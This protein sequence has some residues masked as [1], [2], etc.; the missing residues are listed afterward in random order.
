M[1]AARIILRGFQ[2]SR[3]DH[4]THGANTV[5]SYYHF[6]EGPNNLNRSRIHRVN[7]VLSLLYT[8][9]PS[10]FNLLFSAHDQQFLFFLPKVSRIKDQASRLP[11]CLIISGKRKGKGTLEAPSRDLVMVAHWLAYSLRNF[12]C[13]ESAKR[14]PG[15]F[16]S[17]LWKV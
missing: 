1:Q 10:S 13:Y 6:C 5:L 12:G 16:R 3:I 7:N 14:Y 15:S 8:F 11:S 9:S 2:R 4:E 17:G